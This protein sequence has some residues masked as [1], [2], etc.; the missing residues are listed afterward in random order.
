MKKIEIKELPGKVSAWMRKQKEERAKRSSIGMPVFRV[1][2]NRKV[3]VI[4]WGLL[5]FSLAFAVYKNFTAVNKETVYEREVVEERV[6][7]TNQ[8]ES[9]VRRFAEAF[10]AWGYDM[11]SKDIRGAEAAKYMTEELTRL[12]SGTISSECPTASE[13]LAVNIWEVK[14]LENHCYRVTYSVRQKLTEATNLTAEETAGTDAE[15]P[16]DNG[17][18]GTDVKTADVTSETISE[19]FFETTVY[20]GDDGTMVIVKNPTLASAPEKASYQPAEK[21][22]DGTVTVAE[23]EEIEGFFNTFFSLYPTA[24]EKE[25]TYYANMDVLGAINRN[26]I[27]DGL[28]DAAYYRE[29]GKITVHV[30]VRYLDQTA[31]IAEISEY[32]FVMEKGDNWKIVEVK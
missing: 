3:I 21:K 22:S 26:L 11:A 16:A 29:E 18:T 14:E 15:S 7:D 24:T 23:Q 31:K 20:R 25:L 30:Y 32:T 17:D 10:Y 12:N 6:K 8:V 4:L 1:G 28:L 27:Y 5:L 9:F 13:V 19:T 2:P